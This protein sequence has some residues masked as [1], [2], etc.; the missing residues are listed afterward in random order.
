MNENKR[1]YPRREIKVSV[2]L[3][4]HEERH[5]VV[6]TR[7]ISEG[8]MF[9][10]INGNGKYTIGELVHLHFLDPLNH[11]QDTFKDSIIVRVAGDGI[12]VSHIELD[13]F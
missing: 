9:I 8:G 1:R 10:E 12:A 3:A 2:E 11:D 7:D 6:N 4:F 5:Q 13:A